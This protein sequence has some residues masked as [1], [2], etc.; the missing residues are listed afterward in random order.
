MTRDEILAEMVKV[1]EALERPGLKPEQIARGKARYDELETEL[2]FLVNQERKEAEKNPPTYNYDP[3][4]KEH[5][6]KIWI[7]LDPDGKR[8]RKK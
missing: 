5:V 2:A 4:V 8:R 6:D 3:K 1:A 7:I